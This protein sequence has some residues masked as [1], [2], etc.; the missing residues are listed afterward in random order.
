M[1]KAM[2]KFYGKNKLCRSCGKEVSEDNQECPF[3]EGELT[4]PGM[5]DGSTGEKPK[6]K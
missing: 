3:C 4:Y 6:K 1:G 2:E 5:I